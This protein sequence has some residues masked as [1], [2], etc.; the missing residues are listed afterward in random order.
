[1]LWCLLLR[2]CL[3]F[4]RW[5]LVDTHT[6]YRLLILLFSQLSRRLQM[7][8]LLLLVRQGG[9]R[10]LSTGNNFPFNAQLR[11]SRLDFHHDSRGIGAIMQRR[12]HRMRWRDARGHAVEGTDTGSSGGNGHRRNC[13]SGGASLDADERDLV[14]LRQRVGLQ[15]WAMLGREGSV[16]RRG[17]TAAIA[18]LGQLL[19][20]RPLGLETL[21]RSRWRGRR[22]WEG[23]RGRGTRSE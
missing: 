5:F 7:Y 22:P 3:L 10:R 20:R 9:G 12:R 21:W 16:T 4:W 18:A 15:N 2:R 17:S 13:G 8:L 1:M 19:S 6:N 23:L 14:A 11:E